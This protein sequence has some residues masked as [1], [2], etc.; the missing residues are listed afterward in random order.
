M[1]AVV[2][3]KRACWHREAGTRLL[4]WQGWY[5][6]IRSTDVNNHKLLWGWRLGGYWTHDHHNSWAAILSGKTK[7]NRSFIPDAMIS[8][9]TKILFILFSVRIIFYAANNLYKFFGNKHLAITSTQAR[10][11]TMEHWLQER[12]FLKTSAL[13]ECV[14]GGPNINKPWLRLSP[15]SLVTKIVQIC[16]TFDTRFY[17]LYRLNMYQQKA[18]GRRCTSHSLLAG[19]LLWLMKNLS[20][21][22]KFLLCHCETS[23]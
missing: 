16:S 18:N 22:S 4:R 20:I 21:F 19:N 11:P 15:F 3:V 8:S 13:P 23:P 17:K 10:L 2:L 5:Q 1:I 9:A 6:C 7:S 12:T 14:K